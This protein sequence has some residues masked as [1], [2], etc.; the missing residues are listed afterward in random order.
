MNSVICHCT[1]LSRIKTYMS[2]KFIRI[3]LIIE[4]DKQQAWGNA[5]YVPQCQPRTKK[6][7]EFVSNARLSKDVTSLPG[8]GKTYGQRLKQAGYYTVSIE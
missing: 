6:H 4:T 1:F 8:I 2:L 3:V 5:T 7:E